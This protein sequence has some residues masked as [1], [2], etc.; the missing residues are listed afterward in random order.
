MEDFLKRPYVKREEVVVVD[1][2]EI[3]ARKAL[4]KYLF[5]TFNQLIIFTIILRFIAHEDFYTSID[6]LFILIFLVLTFLRRERLFKLL[7]WAIKGEL[8]S[9]TITQ[10][11]LI[12]NT[13][14]IDKPLKVML[15][16][17]QYFETKCLEDTYFSSNKNKFDDTL[18]LIINNKKIIF[19]IPLGSDIIL[20]QK[21]L[22]DVGLTSIFKYQEKNR[23]VLTKEAKFRTKF[24]YKK[25]ASTTKTN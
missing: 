18:I 6:T 20:V 7:S 3:S 16:S 2:F 5:F 4:I 19:D 8:W 22:E 24:Y 25:S 14:M 13:P 10:D 23:Y 9:L 17:I 11:A 1:N 21:T 12:L 15:S